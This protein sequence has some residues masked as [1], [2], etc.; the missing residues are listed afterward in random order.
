MNRI[1][2]INIEKGEEQIRL[3]SGKILNIKVAVSQDFKI[4]LISG[5][6]L[7]ITVAVSQD[8][9]IRPISGKILKMLSESAIRFLKRFSLSHES[10]PSGLLINNLKQFCH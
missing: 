1:F 8:F 7:K 2:A 10:N 6:I 3:T 4:R 5:K 9:K